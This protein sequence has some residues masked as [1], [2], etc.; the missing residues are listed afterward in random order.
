MVWFWYNKD[1]KTAQTSCLR[2]TC[3]LQTSWQPAAPQRSWA[4]CH[5][6][7][8]HTSSEDT[9]IITV[10]HLIIDFIW[11]KD[12]LHYVCC[13]KDETAVYVYWQAGKIHCSWQLHKSITCKSIY[14][15]ISV[16]S[17]I[18]TTQQHHNRL[19]NLPEQYML[20]T[21][22][23]SSQ[24][25]FLDLTSKRNIEQLHVVVCHLLINLQSLNRYVINRSYNELAV[26]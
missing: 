12:I 18:K 6:V 10:N 3:T 4:L 15:C 21:E 13:S 23:C 5:P 1:K 9:E 16:Y 26:S 25:P 20:C 19:M 8:H 11:K 2:W 7:Q 24:H 17:K 22:K 14:I